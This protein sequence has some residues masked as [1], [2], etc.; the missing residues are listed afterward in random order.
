MTNRR[1]LEFHFDCRI[2]L[3]AVARPGGRSGSTLTI[4][5][6]R[7]KHKSLRRTAPGKPRASAGRE[8]AP[9]GASRWFDSPANRQE[10]R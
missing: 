7:E 4:S 9:R 2:L 8:V 3:I 6:A 1:P 10:P 5:L